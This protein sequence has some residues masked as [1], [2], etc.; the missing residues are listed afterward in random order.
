MERIEPRR[1]LSAHSTSRQ[2][3]DPCRRAFTLEPPP[4]LCDGYEVS[5]FVLT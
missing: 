2:R 4:V 1:A 3:H 5:L